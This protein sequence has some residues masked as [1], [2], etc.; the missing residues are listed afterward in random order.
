M[1]RRSQ[2]L[3]LTEQP[4]PARAVLIGRRSRPLTG[5]EGRGP[6][7]PPMLGSGLR[8]RRG[9]R[10]LPA[11]G[12]LPSNK[13]DVFGGR[14]RTSRSMSRPRIDSSLETEQ[15]RLKPAKVLTRD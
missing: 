13:A 1:Q 3:D 8:V 7:C 9:G 12:D 10:C 11:E 14:V 5:Q 4:E 15:S 6:P 2:L